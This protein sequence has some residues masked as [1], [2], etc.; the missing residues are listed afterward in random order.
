[1]HHQSLHHRQ[2][3]NISK[4][5]LKKKLSDSLVTKFLGRWLLRIPQSFLLVFKW[6]R[7]SPEFN[8]FPDKMSYD[9][10]F[11]LKI[12]ILTDVTFS[13]PTVDSA[14]YVSLSPLCAFFYPP[15]LLCVFKSFIELEL[16]WV[17]PYLFVPVYKGQVPYYVLYCKG[18]V[19]SLKS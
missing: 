19:A 3:H 8:C 6:V 9:P 18:K 16:G 2:F 14:V 17:W 4:G 1:M 12:D 15:S 13:S 5:R 11:L 7:I 10:P